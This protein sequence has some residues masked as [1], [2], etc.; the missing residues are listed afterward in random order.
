MPLL[1]AA[2]PAALPASQRSAERRLL[3]VCWLG[4]Q[5][6]FAS[7]L[8]PLLLSCTDRVILQSAETVLQLNQSWKQMY[9]LPQ[10]AMSSK[11]GSATCTEAF[12]SPSQPSHT[13]DLPVRCHTSPA[14]QA[15]TKQGSVIPP[16]WSH[17][18]ALRT[19]H[20]APRPAAPEQFSPA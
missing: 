12:C 7:L 13:H 10:G 1:S 6:D 16:V 4:A 20:P 15:H 3:A 11:Q 8:L 19:T 14:K 17:L 9:Q 2:R 5:T 18:A